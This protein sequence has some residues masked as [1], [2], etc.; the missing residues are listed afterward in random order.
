M[1]ASYEIIRSTLLAR[2][3]LLPASLDIETT[4]T[5]LADEFDA[6]QFDPIGPDA[7]GV[8]IHGIPKRDGFINFVYNRIS[9]LECLPRNP[10]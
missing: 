7:A 10:V 9:A 6:L 4:A 2:R 3:H 8:L 5:S 1:S